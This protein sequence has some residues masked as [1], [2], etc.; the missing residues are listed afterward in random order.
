M[1]YSSHFTK[2]FNDSRYWRNWSNGA[3]DCAAATRNV[4]VRAMVRNRERAS[5]IAGS[6]VE[7][8]EGDFDAPTLL[9]ALAGVRAF[10]LTNSSNTQKRNKLLSSMQRAKAV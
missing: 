2:I 10:L 3:G 6:N 5:A 1:S 4:Q 7:V 9:G 8:V